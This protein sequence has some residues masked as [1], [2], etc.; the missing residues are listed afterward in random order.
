MWIPGTLW[1]L[2]SQKA[3]QQKRYRSTACRSRRRQEGE[4]RRR[5]EP[6][7]AGEPARIFL[8]FFRFLSVRVSTP[9]R[10]ACVD[11]EGPRGRVELCDTKTALANKKEKNKQKERRRG[12]WGPQLQYINTLIT[13]THSSEQILLEIE[14]ALK[15][16]LKESE[17]RQLCIR[18]NAALLLPQVQPPPLP[19]SLLPNSLPSPRANPH[20]VSL[21]EI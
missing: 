5:R 17:Q 6:G 18:E 15:L 13:P 4:A 11:G 3:R 19:P 21:K 1:H 9:R 8:E 12:G 10:G 20:L 14:S 7:G 2:S 16:N